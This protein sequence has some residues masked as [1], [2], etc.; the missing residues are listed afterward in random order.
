MKSVCYVSVRGE[1]VQSASCDHTY[2]WVVQNEPTEDADGLMVYKCSKCGAIIDSKRIDKLS[3]NYSQ[4]INKNIKIVT[5][6]KA[7]Q[8]VIIDLKSWNSIP[9]SFFEA[10]E[11][12][13]TN[14]TVVVRYLYKNKVYE[15]TVAP[16]TVIDTTCD[17]YGPEKLIV[18]Y[19]AKVVNEM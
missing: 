11:K 14:T 13:Q 10:L 8:T 3:D 4:A 15:F 18:Q 6:A 5:Q 2:E 9:K 17:Y 19:G 1:S 16:D 12:R 7:G